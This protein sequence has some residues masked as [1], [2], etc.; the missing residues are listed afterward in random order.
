MNKRKE[1]EEKQY[2][3]YGIYSYFVEIEKNIL[4]Q[5]EKKFLKIEIWNDGVYRKQ[6]MYHWQV[7]FLLLLRKCW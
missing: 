6:R 5:N 2:E 4:K 3:T 1:K 7:M